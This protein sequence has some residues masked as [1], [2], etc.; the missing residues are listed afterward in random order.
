MS[1][2]NKNELTVEEFYKL[3]DQTEQ[4]MEYIDGVVFMSPSPSTAHQRISGRLHAKLFNFLEGKEREVFHA[5]FDI[6]LKNQEEN[7]TKIVVPDLS[8]ICDKSGLTDQRYVGVPDVIIEIISPS[9]QS[10][11]LVTK[12]NIYMQYG[13]NEYWIV[14]P[15][16]NT[17]QLYTLNEQG[18]YHQMDVVREIGVVQSRELP[19]FQV[20]VQTLFKF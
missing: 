17:V 5:P 14:N 1:L 4:V 6:E 7:G 13:V 10:N 11:D 2:P 20:D 8:V 18:Q 16:L 15:L 9:N 19:G 12:L 3:R